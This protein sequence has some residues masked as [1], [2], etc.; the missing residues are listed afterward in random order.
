MCVRIH[1]YPTAETTYQVDEHMPNCET[2]EIIPLVLKM[3]K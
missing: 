2:E 3:Q 1:M